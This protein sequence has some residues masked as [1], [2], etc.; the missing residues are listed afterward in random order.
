MRRHGIDVVAWWFPGGLDPTAKQILD[1]LERQKV[2]TQ[3]WVSLGDPAPAG[4]QATKVQAAADILRP[5]AAAADKIGCQVALYNHGGWFGEPANQVAIIKLLGMPNVGIVYNFHHGHPH[6]DRFPELFRQMQPY[7]L[8]INL[9]G[10]VKDGDAQGKK[11]LTLGQ[12]DQELNM[13][14]VIRDSGWRGPVGIIDHLPDTDSEVTLREN[15]E[16]LDRLRTALSQ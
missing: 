1:A 4:D 13:M 5:I 12:G 14:R 15:L 7:L 11:I 3:L 16:G 8:A 6:I 9:N 10:M 2:R